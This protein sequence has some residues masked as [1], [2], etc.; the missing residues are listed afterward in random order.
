M[1]KLNLSSGTIY[2][3]ALLYKE[4]YFRVQ[5]FQS[6][7]NLSYSERCLQNS[8]EEDLVVSECLCALISNY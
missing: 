4:V 6:R 7:V 3:M 5:F 2:F 1:I 8:D